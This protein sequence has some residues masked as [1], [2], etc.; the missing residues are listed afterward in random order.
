[1]LRA[2]IL[3]CAVAIMLNLAFYL[4]SGDPLPFTLPKEPF[5]EGVGL[6]EL[7]PLIELV[8]GGMALWT[9]S[10]IGRSED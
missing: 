3:S 8:I 5:D 2:I 9:Y 1:M 6:D 7:M 4:A 10:L